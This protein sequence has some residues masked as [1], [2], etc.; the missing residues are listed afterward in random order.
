METTKTVYDFGKLVSLTK[1]LTEI[2]NAEAEL[3]RKMKIDDLR[4]FQ[5]EKNDIALE[6]EKQQHCIKGS[7]EIRA[8]L[9]E[10]QRYTLKHIALEFDS[11]LQLYQR[12]LFKAQSVNKMIIDKITDVVRE[13]V[14]KNRTYNS[15]GS[16]RLS[17]TELARNTPALKINQQI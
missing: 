9:T 5:A 14:E 1:R 3:L 4:A 11:A 6:L 8:S 17:G 13:Q 2:V 7:A 10:E 15:Y 16:T 12:E